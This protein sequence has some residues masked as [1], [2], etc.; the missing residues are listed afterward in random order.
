MAD[1]KIASIVNVFNRSHLRTG[2]C[3]M[4]ETKKNHFPYKVSRGSTV[5]AQHSIPNKTKLTMELSLQ[6]KQQP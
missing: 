2:V 4:G 5:T 6:A 1:V 3:H